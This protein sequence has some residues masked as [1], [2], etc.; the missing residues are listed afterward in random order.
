[1]H[2]FSNYS[3]W[4]ILIEQKL[5]LSR[6]MS[7]DFVSCRTGFRKPEAE[8]YQFAIDRLGVAPETCLLIDD[9]EKN[10][11]GARQAGMQA[12]L[13]PDHIDALREKLREYGVTVEISSASP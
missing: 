13:R 9:R 8:A 2:A 5:A 3:P 11:A 10:V 6:Y 4:Y 1:M 7:W 12:I